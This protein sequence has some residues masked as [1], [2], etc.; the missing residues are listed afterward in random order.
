MR[1]ASTRNIVGDRVAGDHRL[2]V[3]PRHAV[4][5]DVEPAVDARRRPRQHE[6]Q[7]GDVQRQVASAVQ[8]DPGERE[9][10]DCAERAGQP[11]EGAE[12]HGPLGRGERQQQQAD[13]GGADQPP[14]R[15]AGHAGQPA[16]AQQHRQHPEQAQQQHQHGEAAGQRAVD[17]VLDGQEV[18]AQEVLVP[19]DR[20]ADDVLDA[21]GLG[22][23]GQRLV[24]EDDTKISD[25]DGGQGGERGQQAV[26]RRGGRG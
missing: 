15:A 7:C 25:S 14:D 1:I 4:V 16:A 26:G 10:G 21:G 12:L 9:R 17:A 11:G 18:V 2:P 24:A 6:Q 5:A 13:R 3:E 8:A 19:G 22:D 20:R 23:G